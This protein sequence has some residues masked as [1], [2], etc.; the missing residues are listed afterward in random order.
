MLNAVRGR[1]KW[2]I[3][4]FLSA[5]FILLMLF[6]ILF[7]VRPNENFGFRHQGLIYAL[8]G[9]FSLVLAYLFTKLLANLSSR[10]NHV[11]AVKITMIIVFILS[12]LLFLAMSLM[13]V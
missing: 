12:T 7:L 1:W 5:L 13:S 10:P 3:F 2:F 11:K 4:S 6:T 8:I 9:I